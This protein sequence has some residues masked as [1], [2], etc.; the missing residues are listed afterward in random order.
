MCAHH[1]HTDC[2][3]FHT[4]VGKW[5]LTKSCLLEGLMSFPAQSVSKVAYCEKLIHSPGPARPQ[6]TPLWWSASGHWEHIKTAYV[7]FQAPNKHQTSSAPSPSVNSA[8]AEVGLLEG[9]RVCWRLCQSRVKTQQ[10]QRYRVL[11]LTSLTPRH[12]T[13]YFQSEGCVLHPSCQSRRNACGRIH[14]DSAPI[15]SYMIYF[16]W[17]ESLTT[18]HAIFKALGIIWSVWGWK[19]ELYNLS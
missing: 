18:K 12:G 10:P 9:S 4:D 5:G 2:I 3:P 14:V 13:F 16:E 8:H 17:D 7:L 11:Y 1:T 15:F 19:V 6:N